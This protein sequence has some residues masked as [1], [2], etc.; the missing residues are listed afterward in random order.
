MLLMHDN[1]V[2]HKTKCTIAHICHLL[3]HVTHAISICLVNID[4][5][6]KLLYYMT[7]FWEP[8]WLVRLDH[9]FISTVC[10]F[11]LNDYHAI[12][13]FAFNMNFFWKTRLS[14][15]LL[16]S[17]GRPRLQQDKKFCVSK[18]FSKNHISATPSLRWLVLLSKMR[19]NWICTLYFARYN[20]GCTIWHRMPQKP[21]FSAFFRGHMRR[22]WYSVKSIHSIFPLWHQASGYS[23]K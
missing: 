13:I 22:W 21:I 16:C 6:Y 11:I 17:L 4:A 2:C 7:T 1:M 8:R 3:Q 15:S 9:M 18:D 5:F 12:W 10:K 23:E 20:F 14:G 19:R